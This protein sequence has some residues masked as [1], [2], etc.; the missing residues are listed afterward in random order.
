MAIA[1]QKLGLLISRTLLDG[2][3][4]GPLRQKTGTAAEAG[5]KPRTQ[6]KLPRQKDG[7]TDFY[8]L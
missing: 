6:H 3:A 4:W 2:A 7:T 1:A 8:L 5:G